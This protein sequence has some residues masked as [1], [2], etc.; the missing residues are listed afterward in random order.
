MSG[1]DVGGREG[2]P[3]CSSAPSQRLSSVLQVKASS[4]GRPAAASSLTLSCPEDG[5]WKDSG[6]G[7]NLHGCAGVHIN[8]PAFFPPMEGLQEFTEYLSESLE[9]DSPFLLLE[10]PSTVGFLKLSRPC[11]Y[12]FPGGRGDAAFFAVNGFNLLVNGGSEPRSCFWKLVRHLDRI[13]SVLLTHIGV[14]NL[15][16]LNSLLLRKRA[17]Q[18]LLGGAPAEDEQ[19]KRLISPE[20]GVVFLNAPA[21]LAPPGGDPSLLRSCDEVALTLQH[22]HSLDLQPQ[23][24]SAGPAAGSQPVILFQKMGVGRL[25]L[26][27]L[28]PVR[29]SKVLE[30]FMQLWPNVRRP[31]AELP[32]SC[33]ASICALLV[34]HPSSPQEKIIRVL[35]PG[36]T[37]QS[38][39]L[40]GLQKISKLA[41]LNRPVVC[42]KDLE[43]SKKEKHAGTTES[44]Q[45]IQAPGKE[46]RAGLGSGPSSLKEEPVHGEPRKK[47]VK[48]KPKGT[49]EGALKEKDGSEKPK[50][51]DGEAKPKLTKAGTKAA[52]KKD[53]ETKDGKT[54]GSAEMKKEDGGD[55]KQ[56]AP[57][58]KLKR[59]PRAEPKKEGRKEAKAD[60]SKS[61]KAA[62]KETK[63]AAAWPAGGSALR[64]A[65]AKT[66]S[67]RR[68]APLPKKA[69]AA[70]AAKGQKEAP[71]RRTAPQAA[72]LEPQLSRSSPEKGEAGQGVGGA[73]CSSSGGGDDPASSGAPPAPEGGECAGPAGTHPPH[74]NGHLG[75]ES[76]GASPLAASRKGLGAGLHVHVHEAELWDLGSAA[77]H[78]VD[79]CLVTPCEFQ[80]PK[81]PES[82][83]QPAGTPPPE[84][85]SS[86]SSPSP[87][88][89]SPPLDQS[90]PPG[91][92]GVQL[93]LD[94]PPAPIKDLPPLPP[95]P[96]ACTADAENKS[97]KTSAAK[98]RKGPGSTLRGAPGASSTSG[99]GRVG[100]STGSLS[101]PASS[102]AAAARA[103]PSG[104]RAGSRRGRPR[105]AL[106]AGP[107]LAGSCVAYVDLAYLPSG[108]AAA[109][110]DAEFFTRLR[111]LHYIISGDD[112]VK[113]A[114]MRS[115]LDAL[116]EGK[117][118]WPQVQVSGLRVDAGA[119]APLLTAPPGPPAGDPHP[120]L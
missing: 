51:K 102:R 94:P 47:E 43:A 41:F 76:E 50:G 60:G 98:S 21:S 46:L 67:L 111:S 88:H 107:S 73:S 25:E 32:L 35:F 72:Q 82:Q 119:G 27:V 61:S 13:D 87:P 109:T 69:A 91:H 104:R 65:G 86:S 110:V 12:I 31:S 84:C 39:V 112:E 11:C 64:T 55:K 20:V 54:S 42:L 19:A 81:A 113:A 108:P 75:P 34:W 48:A 93:S 77:P 58:P 22:L 56:E 9:P 78:D 7:E 120:N 40:E 4:C 30:S 17:E 14:D 28:N 100:G 24:L 96:G 103:P 18:E 92:S 29:G 79:L 16:G 118:R 105:Q 44:D 89:S 70:A 8:P 95:Q 63:K 57:G 68:D 83:Q 36:C 45:S 38:N 5:L 115:I 116:L 85:P 62:S 114:A 59:D 99:R 66:V 33:L 90:P 97:I 15:P 52:P 3:D 26:Y 49:S 101:T 23:S 6:L 2:P 37:P 1:E 106:T 117:S 80:H 10:P 53:D 71:P 74:L